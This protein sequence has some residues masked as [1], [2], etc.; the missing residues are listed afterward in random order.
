[1]EAARA[2]IQK[3]VKEGHHGP[4]VVASCEAL[5]GSVTFSLEPNVWLEEEWPEEGMVVFLTKLREKRAGWRAMEGRF[6]RPSDE[7]NQQ[8]ARSRRMHTFLYPTSR[9]FP[10]DAAC[11]QI[12][13][14]LEARNWNVPG[15]TVEFNTYGSGEE[16]YRHVSRIRSEDF[17]L[18][19]CR[20]QGRLGDGHWNDIAAVTKLNIPLR[21]LH[22]YEDRSGPTFYLYVGKNWKRDRE[23]FMKSLKVN[24][25]LY[26]E[27]RMYLKYSGGHSF[28]THDNDLNR[29]YG[30]KPWE[31]KSLRIH[32]VMSQFTNYLQRIV[33]PMIVAHPVATEKIDHFAE[34]APIPYPESIGPLFCFAEPRDA[35]RINEGK[36]NPEKLLARHRF[37]L[38]G[39]GYRL[40]PLG[41]S[42]GNVPEIAFDGFLWCGIGTV[43]DKMPI[44]SV[45]VPGHSMGSFE[46]C[47]VRVLPNRANGIYVADQ[48]VFDQRRKEIAD[49][50]PQL[51]RFTDA[52]VRDFLSARGRTIIPL[53][54]YKGNY[55]I[56]IVLINRELGFDEVEVVSEPHHWR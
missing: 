34:P 14:E 35:Q 8:P 20:S 43:D 28:L 31:P 7:I 45:E 23:K 38:H 2:V 42:D 1:M 51:K 18:W 55:K 52:D 24:S 41:D 54:E 10:F 29:E 4:F 13:R 6:W 5:E 30:P 19:F 46:N 47:L 3:V 25:K 27:P 16:K 36:K 11:E 44:G 49:A 17:E 32:V 37:G 9:I 33:L 26:N 40:V 53:S 50:N 21:E 12:V 56:P 48:A 15:V 22:V 39:S